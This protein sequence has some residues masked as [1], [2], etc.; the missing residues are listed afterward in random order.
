MHATTSGGHM[1]T[2]VVV[3][4]REQLASWC[5]PGPGG[6]QGACSL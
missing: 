3:V 4:G 1:D 2:T 6:W 5:S